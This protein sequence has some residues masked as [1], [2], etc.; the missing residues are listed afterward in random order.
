MVDISALQNAK[1]IHERANDK[2]RELHE[3]A[4]QADDVLTKIRA[5]E[6]A[7]D[8]CDKEWIFSDDVTVDL[9]GISMGIYRVGHR[10]KKAVDAMNSRIRCIEDTMGTLQRLVE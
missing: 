8:E 4:E 9:N 7:I 10:V 6:C 3:L 1:L 2:L 5:A